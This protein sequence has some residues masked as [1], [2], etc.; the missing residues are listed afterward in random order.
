[1]GATSHLST[2]GKGL[3]VMLMFIGRVG[4][5]ALALALTQREIADKLRYPTEE[6]V[7]G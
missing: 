6:V 4:P 1:M 3:I 2:V 5:L 7:I